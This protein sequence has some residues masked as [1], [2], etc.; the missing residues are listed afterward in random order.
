MRVKAFALT[1]AIF[2]VGATT[3]KE[4][5]GKKDFKN[6]VFILLKGVET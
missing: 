3:R 4:M 2:Y 1:Q 6:V 5:H